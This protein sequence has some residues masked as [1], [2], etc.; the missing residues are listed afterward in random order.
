V[1]AAA[2]DPVDVATADEAQCVAELDAVNKDTAAAAKNL[3]ALGAQGLFETA[4]RAHE[5]AVH[6]LTALRERTPPA[7]TPDGEDSV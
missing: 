2:I 6:A 5:S 1:R 4:T 3:L 7:N